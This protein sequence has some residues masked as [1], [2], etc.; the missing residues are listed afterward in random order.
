MGDNKY[1]MVGST[2]VAMVVCDDSLDGSN[3]F[4]RRLTA[5]EPDVGPPGLVCLGLFLLGRVS[6]AF[7]SILAKLDRR[8]WSRCGS[9]RLSY[10]DRCRGW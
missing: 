3:G 9:R 4:V 10:D 7:L 6:R 2:F 5:K 1:E 8:R